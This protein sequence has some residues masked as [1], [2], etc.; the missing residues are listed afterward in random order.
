MPAYSRTFTNTEVLAMAGY[1]LDPGH[2][3]LDNEQPMS[4]RVHDGLWDHVD[5]RC[6]LGDIRKAK[7]DFYAGLRT[8]LAASVLLEALKAM[9][10]ANDSAVT[11]MMECDTEEGALEIARQRGEA[12][13]PLIEVARAAIAQAEAA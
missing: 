7:S 12:F 11:A 4:V 3:D 13:S 6:L 9:V 5:L 8:A 2:S 1:Q 10:R